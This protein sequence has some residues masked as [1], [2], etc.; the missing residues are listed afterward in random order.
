[1]KLWN[2]LLIIIFLFQGIH[3]QLFSQSGFEEKFNDNQLKWLE[4]EN[5]EAVAKVQ[6]GKYEIERIYGEGSAFNCWQKLNV[7]KDVEF[8]IEANVEYAKGDTNMGAGLFLFGLD[9]NNYY[10]FLVSAN[11]YYKFSYYENGESKSIIPWTP[12]EHVKKLGVNKLKIIRTDKQLQLLINNQGINYLNKP[13]TTG[14]YFGFTVEGKQKVIFDD[15]KLE[16]NP[17]PMVLKPSNLSSE[18]KGRKTIYES[19]EDFEPYTWYEKNDQEAILKSENGGLLFEYK[20]GSYYATWQQ[21]LVDSYQDYVISLNMKHLDGSSQHGYGFILGAQNIDNGYLLYITGQGWLS[22][23]QITNGNWKTLIQWLPT[24]AYKSADWNNLAILKKSG[25][26]KIYLNDQFVSE[27]PAGFFEGN[28]F[29]ISIFDRQKV[30][31]DDFNI[32][33]LETEQKHEINTFQLAKNFEKPI[34]LKDSTG[35]F[36]EGMYRAVEARVKYDSLQ[37]QVGFQL[38]NKNNYPIIVHLTFQMNCALSTLPKEYSFYIP[39][40]QTATYLLKP[41]SA[42]KI[43]NYTYRWNVFLP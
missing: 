39:E 40:N 21:R 3:N 4:V 15:L 43:K 41:C 14:Q 17:A 32:S 10:Y 5:A 22:L 19:K 6:Q 11:G 36:T 1:M 31:F 2:K 38:H 35:Y 29:G 13:V 9:G 24:T 20:N 16:S 27:C 30:L 12:N 28:K 18:I 8:S 7:S 37:S 33:Q 26:W 25:I 23:H 42:D 34:Q